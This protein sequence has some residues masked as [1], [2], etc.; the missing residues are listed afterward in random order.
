MQHHDLDPV[1]LALGEEHF[2][3]SAELMLV[4]HPFAGRW[5]F[6]WCWRGEPLLELEPY[7]LGSD[8]SN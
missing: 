8:A 7:E 5:L 4:A 2:A 1:E 6:T 3:I